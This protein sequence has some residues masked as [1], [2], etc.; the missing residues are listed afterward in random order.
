[1]VDCSG[2][3]RVIPDTSLLSM[4]RGTCVNRTDK[5]ERET[6]ERRGF[7]THC[8]ACGV[9]SWDVLQQIGQV[10]AWGTIRMKA[11]RRQEGMASRGRGDSCHN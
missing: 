10:D 7:I 5:A 3:Q 11:Q 9:G 1:V 6:I 4:S 2:C 8:S